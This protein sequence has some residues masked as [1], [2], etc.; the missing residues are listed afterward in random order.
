MCHRPCGYYAVCCSTALQRPTVHTSCDQTRFPRRLPSPLLLLC[1]L[2]FQSY[3]APPFACLALPRLAPPCSA[4]PAPQHPTP[5]VPRGARPVLFHT[6]RHREPHGL[7]PHGTCLW[8]SLVASSHHVL[9]LSILCSHTYTHT[10]ISP[11]RAL[12]IVPFTYLT[13]LP[14]QDGTVAYCFVNHKKL[15]SWGNPSA[16][17][18][19]SHRAHSVRL[20]LP[21]PPTPPHPPRAPRPACLPHNTRAFLFPDTPSHTQPLYTP[22]CVSSPMRLLCRVLLHR[23]PTTYG[24]HFLRSNPLPPSPPLPPSS[25]LYAELSILLSTTFCMPRLAPPCSALLR[26]ACPPTPHPMRASWCTSRAVP[27]PAPP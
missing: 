23:A 20:S 19:G 17:G 22:P 27:H 6:L 1:M 8:F 13:L 25:P 3:S 21:P 18:D 15:I 9:A 10:L 5:C 2:N 4:L 14:P 16:S 24:P 12:S 7:S 26:L 11:S